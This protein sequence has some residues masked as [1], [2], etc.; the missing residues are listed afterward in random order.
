MEKK[1]T[2]GSPQSG[3][4]TEEQS[5]D[6]FY[7]IL[8]NDEVNTFD[9]VIDSLIKVCAHQPQQAEQCAYITHFRGKCDVKRGAQEQ[10]RPLRNSLLDLGLQVTI[11]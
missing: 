10:L 9:H 4:L 5:D 1:V 8:H 3:R 11:D 7:L 2:K 6:L